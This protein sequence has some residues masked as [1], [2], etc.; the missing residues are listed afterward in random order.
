MK[1]LMKALKLIGKAIF[2]LFFGLFVWAV[3]N[4]SYLW[5]M[6]PERQKICDEVVLAIAAYHKEHGRHPASLA[7]IKIEGADICHYSRSQD[8]YQLWFPGGL[9]G[10][11]VYWSAKG[12]WVDD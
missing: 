9:L 6:Q 10:V 4:V 2:W 1:T 11:R 7:D 12:Q 3:A 8:D 5:L